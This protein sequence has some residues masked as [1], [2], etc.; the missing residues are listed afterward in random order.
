[1]GGGFRKRGRIRT[2]VQRP[3]TQPSPQRGRVLQEGLN[4]SAAL[5]VAW[6]NDGQKVG[7]APAQHLVRVQRDLLLARMRGGHHPYLAP[8]DL[9]LQAA[10][11]RFV[12]GQR[13]GGE[14]EIAD[15]AHVAQPQRGKALALDF[16]LRQTQRERAEQ[17]PRPAFHK[18][19]LAKGF[20]RHAPVQQNR[21]NGAAAQSGQHVGPQFGLDPQSQIRP[22]MIEKAR[23]ISPAIHRDILMKHARRQARGQQLRGRDRA[24]GQKNAPVRIGA[25]Q[26]FGEA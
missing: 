1:M 22:P 26:G 4:G 13:L 12:A 11:F 17:L 23:H 19:P 10:Q 3:P 9:G 20:L 2:S 21:R 24:G 16:G 15:V 6:D 5:G 18:A 14:F 8:A 7:P 25:A